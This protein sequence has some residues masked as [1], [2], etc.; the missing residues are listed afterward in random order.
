MRRG[1]QRVD[2]P[3]SDVIFWFTVGCVTIKFMAE[4]FLH[5]S[6]YAIPFVLWIMCCILLPLLLLLLLMMLKWNIILSLDRQNEKW[7]S[8]WARNGNHLR[9]E[10]KKFEILIYFLG[11]G[12]ICWEWIVIFWFIWLT[13]YFSKFVF[14]KFWINFENKRITF[15]NVRIN[16][17]QFGLFPKMFELSSNRSDYFRKCLY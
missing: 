14:E 3:F 13:G 4:Y 12:L 15:E 5:S 7:D 1:Q 11:Y 8:K 6:C 9:D 10:K 17:K 2:V 16:F